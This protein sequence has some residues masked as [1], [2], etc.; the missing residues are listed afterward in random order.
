MDGNSNIAVK[1]RKCCLRQNATTFN[2]RNAW[3]L[4]NVYELQSCSKSIDPNEN[5]YSGY[6]IGFFSKRWIWHECVIFGVDS[7]SSVHTQ[8]RKKDIT[9]LI[10]VSTQNL[11]T[12]RITAESRYSINFKRSIKMFGLSLHYSESNRLLYVNGV[13]QFKPKGSDIKTYSLCLRNISK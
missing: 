12:T 9:V 11:D 7:S 5:G 10:K 8:N 6:D 4:F 2:H 1:F 3:N 13:Y